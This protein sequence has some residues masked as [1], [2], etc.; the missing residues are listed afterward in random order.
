M[1]NFV[2]FLLILVW[3]RC[4]CLGPQFSFLYP[5]SLL[6]LFQLI[7][8]SKPLRVSFRFPSHVLTCPPLSYRRPYTPTSLPNAWSC[9]TRGWRSS[10]TSN[11]ISPQEK[12]SK[13]RRSRKCTYWRESARSYTTLTSQTRI[14]C[15]SWSST[16]YSVV[17]SCLCS[18]TFRGRCTRSLW[19]VWTAFWS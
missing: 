2:I 17:V 14:K 13:E 6:I 19:K 9:G 5:N 16:S 11:K 10:A 3:K 4:M 8:T 15:G 1:T 18:L 12:I 7:N